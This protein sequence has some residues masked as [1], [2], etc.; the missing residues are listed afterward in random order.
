MTEKKSKKKDRRKQIGQK[1]SELNQRVKKYKSE[2][3]RKKKGHT[4]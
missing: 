3:Q 2:Q 1:Y 4:T